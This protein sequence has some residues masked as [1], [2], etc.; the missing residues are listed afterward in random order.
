LQ[1][2]FRNAGAFDAR[3]SL[4]TARYDDR[5]PALVRRLGAFDALLIVVGS[6]IGS[7]IFRTPSVVAERVHSPELILGAWIGG[8][9]VA[10]FGA[11]VLGELAA[12]RPEGYG[13]YAYLRDAF[14]P[15]VAFAFG[16]I[17]LLVAFTGGLA[18]AALLFAGYFEPLTGLHVSPVVLATGVLA[19]LTIVSC[20]GVR[21]SGNVQNLLTLLKVGAIAGLLVAGIFAHPAAAAASTVMPL[22]PVDTLSNL[23]IAMI[24]VLFAYNGAVVVNFMGPET[25]NPARALPLGLWAGISG[26]IVLYAIV[27]AV[28][29]RVL[30]ADGLAATPTPISD[31]VLA[32][33]GPLGGRLVAA[34]IV[35]ATLGFISNRMLT[36]P[37]LYLAMAQD[38]LFFRQVGWIDPRTHV[39][40]VAIAL[41]GI[42]AIAFAA[43]GSYE[44][45]LNYVVFTTY[46]FAALFAVALIVIRTRDVRSGAQP[47]GR[48]RMPWYPVSTLLVMA[49][50]IA[51]VVDTYVRYPG[52][53]SI[54]L[55]ILV[56]AVPAYFGWKALHAAAR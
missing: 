30:G 24:P 36:V 29:I 4:G 10:L 20:L 28:C 46:I 19:A 49:V 23:G 25:K 14:H 18:A 15:L 26:V 31:V 48:F 55:L 2:T 9:V 13:V 16:W 17:S 27:N 54:A 3:R 35:L 32:V 8:G 47:P 1:I 51:I 33:T 34:A 37:R 7:G 45:I 6:V 50:S 56:S 11:F 53:S 40:V 21:E 52:D 22:S 43:T 39:P 38:G 44:R 42:F 41:Q 12:R 5:L